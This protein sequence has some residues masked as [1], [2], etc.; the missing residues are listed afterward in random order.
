MIQVAYLNN[1]SRCCDAQVKIKYFI[2][3]RYSGQFYK[4]I[5]L[6]LFYNAIILP[7]FIKNR[8]K[9]FIIIIYAVVLSVYFK[10]IKLIIYINRDIML[11]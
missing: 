10:N 3:S 6:E 9:D 4:M 8:E 2:K 5:K 11:I 1:K 7:N